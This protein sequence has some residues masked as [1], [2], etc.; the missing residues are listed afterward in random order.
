MAKS[1][2][3]GPYMKKLKAAQQ[4]HDVESAHCDADQVLC[5]LLKFLGYDKIVE[6]Y[7]KVPKWYA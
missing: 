6:E 4:E 3:L 1:I 5:D 2:N 7:E